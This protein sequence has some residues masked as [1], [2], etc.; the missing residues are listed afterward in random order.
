[1]L[2]SDNFN[3]CNGSWIHPI[4]ELQ[5]GHRQYAALL[6]IDWM[7]GCPDRTVE[8]CT[9]V[10]LWILNFLSH[11]V[12]KLRSRPASN[13]EEGVSILQ[14][15]ECPNSCKR[16]W[17]MVVLP[18][19]G[20]QVEGHHVTW[21]TAEEFRKRMLSSLYSNTVINMYFIIYLTECPEAIIIRLS[22]LVL[23]ASPQIA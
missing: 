14:I 18:L 17:L 8:G 2:S 23:V 16:E 15:C 10:I 9:L 6:T 11:L 5:G 12:D 20:F 22:P 1:M 3:G 21:A 4:E 7:C 19:H 13:T